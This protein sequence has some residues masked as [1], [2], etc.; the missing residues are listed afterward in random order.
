MADW[1]KESA[2]TFEIKLKTQ[3]SLAKT[4]RL[5][6]LMSP[7]TTWQNKQQKTPP[8]AGQIDEPEA[9]ISNPSIKKKQ[10]QKSTRMP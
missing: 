2:C 3:N 5:I 10:I 4:Q 8:P 6:L 9:S 7:H 1:I